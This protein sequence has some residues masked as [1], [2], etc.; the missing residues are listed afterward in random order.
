MKEPKVLVLLS[1]LHVGASAGLLPPDFIS[2]EG[3]EI[4]QNRYQKWLWDSWVKSWKWAD[5][6]IGKDAWLCA[7]NGDLT[8]GLHHDTR[9]VV[10]ADV[11]D[12]IAAAVQTI[13]DVVKGSSGVYI[14]E[15]T[16]V[17]VQNYEHGIARSLKSQGIKIVSP[18]KRKG[19]WPEMDIVINGCR[20]AIDHHVSTS[21]KPAT[22]SSAYSQTL[23]TVQDR[24]CRAGWKVP[25]FLV[26]S[27]RHQF[28]Y[29]TD[30]YRSMV[31]LP[32]W[33]GATR[34]TRRVV[35]RVVPQCGLVI[36]DW[37]NVPFGKP[38]VIHHLIFTADQDN[39][40]FL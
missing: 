2:F 8:D 3:N 35:P 10:S 11:A 4:K 16:N 20:I 37:R 23:S 22:E 21:T 9:E 6:I 38:P 5:E 33:Q 29:F 32:P 15:G 17:H 1:D 26:R 7:I 39:P 24:Y 31:I 28:G 19:A 25:T 14:T 40:E 18:N 13:V 27:H 34:F 36:A 12:H 30:G